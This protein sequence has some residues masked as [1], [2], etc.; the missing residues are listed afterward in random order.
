M[1]MVLLTLCLVAAFAAPTSAADLA[2]TVLRLQGAASAVVGEAARLLRTGDELF[3]G[4]TITTG[5]NTRLRIRL[6][7]GAV[8]TLGDH[9][10]FTL[11]GYEAESN[12]PVL[13]LI[14]GVLLGVSAEIAEERKRGLTVRTPIGTTG[15][16]GTTFWVRQD[17]DGLQ[18]ALIEG[19]SVFVEA[20]ER[21]VILDILRGGVSVKRG[22][23]P[24]EPKRWGDA[25][26]ER[27]LQQVTFD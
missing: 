27:S 12:G 18:V 19:G 1:R 14:Q 5:R 25:R 17:R 3:I 7:E 10:T 13:D 4:E 21:R 6:I 11:Q 22:Q 20:A 9:S 26:I 23:A 2:G 8:I 15:T 24:S 16:R